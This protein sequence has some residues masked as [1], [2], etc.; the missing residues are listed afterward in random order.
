MKSV[1]KW[2]RDVFGFSASEINGFIIL[3]P[4]MVVLLCSEPLYHMWTASQPESKPREYM[5]LDSM[6]IKLA[7][8]IQGPS[9]V[10]ATSLFDFDPNTASV[11]ELRKLGFAEVLAKRIA[12][13]RLKGG[14]FRIKSDLMKIYGLDSTL[15]KQLY[16]HITLPATPARVKP[17]VAFAKPRSGVL[18]K[19]KVPTPFD[20]NTADTLLLKSVYGI[21]PRLAARIIKFRE[22]L[23]GFVK[24]E[25]LYEVYGLDS[26]VVDRLQKV[27]FITP[28][29]KPQRININHANE[30]ELAAHPYIRFKLARLL[31]SYRF[32]HG[33]FIAVTDIK[34]LSVL[35]PA[36]IERLLPYLKVKE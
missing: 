13:Y 10:E 34:K 1:R 8:S 22:S 14:V 26:L 16:N 3:V 15:Y 12:A 23:G 5:A 4:L 29:F 36:E 17:N 2:I 30:K 25:Q 6:L 20:L 27:S 21:G 31:V 19:K 9:D 35:E 11:E 18:E 28:E 33:D 7:G 32:Q 24:S